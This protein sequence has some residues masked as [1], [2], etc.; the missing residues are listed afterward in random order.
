MLRPRRSPTGNRAPC[1]AAHSKRNARGAAAYVCCIALDVRAAGGRSNTSGGRGGRTVPNDSKVTPSLDALRR[2]YHDTRDDA[3]TNTL[4]GDLLAEAERLAG[5]YNT[6]VTFW[7]THAV[8]KDRVLQDV[9][10]ENARLTAALRD[11]ELATELAGKEIAALRVDLD[12]QFDVAN[13]QGDTLESCA[14][15]V[16]RLEAQVATLTAAAQKLLNA[17][18]GVFKGHKYQIQEARE[19]LRRVLAEA[20]P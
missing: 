3:E 8:E 12:K 11:A 10:A 13:A 6:D 17:R 20:K 5:A 4:C 16:E 18:R 15:K 2:R 14:R 19:E 9:R 1:P 7:R